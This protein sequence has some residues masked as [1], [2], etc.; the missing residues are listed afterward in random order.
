MRA[1]F[2]GANIFALG[3]GIARLQIQ[4]L[5]PESTNTKETED[6]DE[7]SGPPKG[8]NSEAVQSGAQTDSPGKMAR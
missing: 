4:P 6:D 5:M 1:A 2:Y 7:G 8:N 3:N